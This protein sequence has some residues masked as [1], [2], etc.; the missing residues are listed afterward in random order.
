V[1]IIDVPLPESAY[2][3]LYRY[4][5]AQNALHAVS[6]ELYLGSQMLAK[7]K[8][9]HTAALTERI[10]RTY[11]QSVL[12]QFSHHAG[13]PVVLFREMVDLPLEQYP[14]PVEGCHLRLPASPADLERWA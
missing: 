4:L 6:C 3:I 12:E 2:A 7:T 1:P 10:V 5:G 9:I 8:P 11:L 13:A 14:C